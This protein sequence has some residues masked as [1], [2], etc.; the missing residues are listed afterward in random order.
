MDAAQLETL[1]NKLVKE[2][3]A[4][5]GLAKEKIEVT[6]PIGVSARHL[7][8][9][10][11]HLEILF[12][13]GAELH[14][15]KELMGGQYAASERVTLVGANLRAIENVRILGP[16]RKETQVEVAHTDA[17][18]LGIKPPVKE[19]GDT[20]GSAP[21]TIV[22]PCGALYL[23]EGCIV[24]KRHI[25]MSEE[26]ARN[27]GF[28]DNQIVSVLIGDERAG[29]FDNVQIRVHKT[30]TL[31]MHIDT[32]EANALGVKCKEVARIVR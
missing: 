9:T 6:V 20:K 3:L 31:E 11:E 14:P 29:R 23:Q 25:H 8:V 15:I 28:V 7:H 21:I 26:D 4:E 13:K 16:V 30:F 19:S 32:D 12:G 1:I 22:G 10:Q 27:F 5:S 17:L 18:K 24:A 2:E